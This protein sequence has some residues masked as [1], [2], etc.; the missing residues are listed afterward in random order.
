MVDQQSG[1]AHHR[2]FR[3]SVEQINVTPLLTPVIKNFL[4]EGAG[5]WDGANSYYFTIFHCFVIV[6][7]STNFCVIFVELYEGIPHHFSRWYRF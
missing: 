6:L 3:N 4:C 5:N 7:L 1:Q 2:F